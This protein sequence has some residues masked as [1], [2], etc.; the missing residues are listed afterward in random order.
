MIFVGAHFLISS[1]SRPMIGI[2]E[3][4]DRLRR[5]VADLERFNISVIK[6][7][8]VFNRTAKYGQL[9]TEISS[10]KRKK[11]LFWLMN[12]LIIKFY[13]R[14]NLEKGEKYFKI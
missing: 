1:K 8:T 4:G 10:Y 14:S 3:F 5:I 13:S 9:R 12:E 2:K 7:L 6:N 11:K